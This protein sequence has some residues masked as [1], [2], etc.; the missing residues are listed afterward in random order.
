MH[1]RLQSYKNETFLVQAN[2]VTAFKPSE[3][4]SLSNQVKFIPKPGFHNPELLTFDD[5]PTIPRKNQNSPLLQQKFGPP[6]V[7]TV[8]KSSPLDDASAVTNDKSLKSKNSGLSTKSSSTKSKSSHSKDSSRSLTA[9]NHS[10]HTNKSD[11][12]SRRS[13]RSHHSWKSSLSRSSRSSQLSRLSSSSRALSMELLEKLKRKSRQGHDATDEAASDQTDSTYTGNSSQSSTTD[14]LQESLEENPVQTD[15]QMD[16][17]TVALCKAFK[18]S[19][20]IPNLSLPTYTSEDKQRWV[21][22]VVAKIST[23][24][25][26]TALLHPRTKH[27]SLRAVQENKEIDKALYDKLE[28]VIPSDKM[29]ILSHKCKDKSDEASFEKLLSEKLNVEFYPNTT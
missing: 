28:K 11:H 16:K 21:N 23:N 12:T 5:P 15:D 4:F 18:E 10:Q 13:A 25:Y 1:I 2:E 29:N 7:I 9:G 20:N 14:T 3:K 6:L 27:L 19:R 8:E 24:N 17:M 22:R 26:F